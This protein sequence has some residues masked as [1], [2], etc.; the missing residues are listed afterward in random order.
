EN[1]QYFLFF[2][3]PIVASVV[4]IPYVV[5][6]TTSEHFHKNFKV[7]V[8]SRSFCKIN[9]SACSV[10]LESNQDWLA[11]RRFEYFELIHVRH[12]FIAMLEKVVVDGICWVT[13]T[14]LLARMVQMVLGVRVKEDEFVVIWHESVEFMFAVT[15]SVIFKTVRGMVVSRVLAF[16]ILGMIITVGESWGRLIPP[17]GNLFE[18]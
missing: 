14:G 7:V 11:V 8:L 5:N 12:K 9:P 15:F 4:V 2:V 1:V 6:P 17:L 13:P 16:F 3:V 10:Y 18:S